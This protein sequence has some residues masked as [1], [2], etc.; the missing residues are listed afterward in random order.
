[1]LEKYS[2]SFLLFL[3]LIVRTYLLHKNKINM[4]WLL[5]LWFLD[6]DKVLLFIFRKALFI[7]LLS[8]N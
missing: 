5:I 7:N 2:K 8:V 6:K 3:V 1:M 4:E